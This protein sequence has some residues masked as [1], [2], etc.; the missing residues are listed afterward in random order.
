MKTEMRIN[1][2][3]DGRYV[4]E[5]IVQ[6]KETGSPN[7]LVDYVSFYVPGGFMPAI[8]NVNVIKDKSGNDKI[9]E[10]EFFDGSVEMAVCQYGDTFDLRTGIERC[11]I[12]KMFSD[13]T[14][15][16]EGKKVFN[17]VVAKA[18]KLYKKRVA[19]EK[20][21]AEQLAAY[22]R[23]QKKKAEKTRKWIERKEA[24][25][26]AQRIAEQTEAYINAIR[27]IRNETVTDSGRMNFDELAKED[28]LK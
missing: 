24:K 16:G 2:N 18:M 21:T 4:A 3:K 22:E 7:F 5:N 19:V 17:K 27:A 12:Y 23:S 25:R 9:V 1:T 10:V 26:R 6:G 11:I 28:D 14:F 8:L 13:A 15:T 20:E